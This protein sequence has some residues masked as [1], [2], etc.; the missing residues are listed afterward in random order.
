MIIFKH[1][2]GFSI[3]EN[4]KIAVLYNLF[5]RVLMLC[6]YRYVYPGYPLNVIFTHLEGFQSQKFWKSIHYTTLFFRA[7]MLYKYSRVS[8]VTLWTMAFTCIRNNKKCLSGWV[9]QLIGALSNTPKGCRLILV[10]AHMGGNQSKVFLSLS[11]S[12]FLLLSPS[13]SHS[14]CLPSSL[15]N[16]NKHILRWGF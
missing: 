13:L 15:S 14:L 2:E 9:P 3:S 1:S 5:F 11:V 4:L 12:F 8:Q 6:T 16:I 10:G 7:L